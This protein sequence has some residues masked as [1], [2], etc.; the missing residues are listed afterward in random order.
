MMY[1]LTLFIMGMIASVLVIIVGLNTNDKSKATQY[2]FIGSI[3]VM[4]LF[5]VYAK[6]TCGPNPFTVKKM[7]PMAEKIS[8][9]IIKNGVPKS[10]KDIPGLPYRLEGCERDKEFDYQENCKFKNKTIELSFQH[11]KYTVDNVRFEKATIEMK[12]SVNNTTE[13]GILIDFEK[14]NGKFVQVGNMSIYSG[15]DSGI[16]SPM[17]Q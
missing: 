2:V 12:K 3:I 15:K 6:Y 17:R 7:K 1:Q 8:E 4:G 16:C 14:K 5:Y 13:T 9:Y 11:G 10:L